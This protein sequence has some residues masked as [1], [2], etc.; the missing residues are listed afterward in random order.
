MGNSKSSCQR[1]SS[2]RDTNKK[3]LYLRTDLLPESVIAGGSI[4]HTLGVIQGFQQLGYN[5]ICASAILQT[6]LQKENVEKVYNLSN[7]RCMQALPNKVKNLFSNIFFTHQVLKIANNHEIS[8]MYQRYSLLNATGIIVKHIKRLPLILEY[9]GSEVWVD[10]YWSKNRFLCIRPIIRFFEWL[11]LV[12]ANYIIVVSQ[13]LYDDL[14]KRGIKA[15]KILVN[16][17]GV[18]TDLY[19]P[20]KL[21]IARAEIRTKLQITNRFVF[22][23]IGTFSPWHGIEMLASIIP[24]V[25]TKNPYIHFLLIGDG[26]LKNYLENRLKYQNINNEHVTFTGSLYH[27]I[28]RTYLAACDAYVSPTQP[29]KDGSRFFGSPTKLFEY[30]SMGK[31]VIASNLEQLQEIISPAF[32]INS[33]ME[34]VTNQVGIIVEATNIENWIQALNKIA[35]LSP[36][37]LEKIGNNARSKAISCYQWQSHVKKIVDFAS[38]SLQ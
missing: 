6:Q 22:G 11:N 28:A 29:N 14:V 16:P 8:C 27:E 19:N 18:N 3:I 34:N 20:E 35:L 38:H 2:L 15:K 7:P 4:A 17:N 13:P 32:N 30:L 31:P 36:Q 12:M 25:I 24:A 9:N 21:Q 5:I 1:Y 23:F 33:D 26:P 10:Q 37:A